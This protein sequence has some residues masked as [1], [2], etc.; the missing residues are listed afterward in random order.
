M[1]PDLILKI[2]HNLVE[3]YDKQSLLAF[4]ASLRQKV[5]KQVE[6]RCRDVHYRWVVQSPA[7]KDNA[8]SFVGTVEREAVYDLS[9]FPF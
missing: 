6:R 5:F 8:S 7:D 2:G 9:L 3:A 4:Y 1:E